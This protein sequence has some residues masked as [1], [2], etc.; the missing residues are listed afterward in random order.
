MA[1]INARVPT[2]AELDA[3]LQHLGEAISFVDELGP[4]ARSLDVEVAA[5]LAGEAVEE[6]FLT[7]DQVGL[8]FM[9]ATEAQEAADQLNELADALL[10]KL[11]D[12]VN[13][14]RGYTA[15]FAREAS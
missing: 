12:L 1:T 4:P 13:R 5:F 6:Q 15:A 7:L 3:F 14:D 11:P 8:L 2:P 9:A 10:G